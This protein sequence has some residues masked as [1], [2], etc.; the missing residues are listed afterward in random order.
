MLDKVWGNFSRSAKES[1]VI[2]CVA[3]PWVYSKGE[4]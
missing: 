3:I 1:L 4:F 2:V